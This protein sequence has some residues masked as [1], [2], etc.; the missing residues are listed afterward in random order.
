MWGVSV[1]EANPHVCEALH[2]GRM[3]LHVVTITAPVLV[4]GGVT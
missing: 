2:A 4:D 1:S 3:Q